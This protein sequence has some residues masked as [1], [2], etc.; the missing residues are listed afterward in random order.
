MTTMMW[1]SCAPRPLPKRVWIHS[2]PV[3][4]FERR[5][6]VDIYTIRKT[7]LKVGQSQGIQ[8]LLTP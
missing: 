3:I 1:A 7:W 6:Q 2:A 5:S 4:T 8:T